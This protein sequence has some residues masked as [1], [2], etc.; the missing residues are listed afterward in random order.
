MD[1]SLDQRGR[2]SKN[3]FSYMHIRWILKSINLNSVVDLHMS[4]E[5]YLPPPYPWTLIEKRTI[6]NHL[7]RVM[8][9]NSWCR[10]DFGGSSQFWRKAHSGSMPPRHGNWWHPTPMSSH[11]TVFKQ[12]ECGPK[13]NY[14]VLVPCHHQHPAPDSW[15]GKCILS[16]WRSWKI[17][18]Q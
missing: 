12:Q 11:Q 13:E 9:R 17:Q 14:W 15:Q 10:K 6:I 18:L 4:M 16:N 8:C 5:Q 1:L 2:H 7:R 3:P